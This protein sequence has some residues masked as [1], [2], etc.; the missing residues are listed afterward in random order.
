MAGGEGGEA[1]EGRKA[2]EGRSMGDAAGGQGRWGEG[3][4]DG[5]GV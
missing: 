1:G 2:D 5:S 3:W 4:G